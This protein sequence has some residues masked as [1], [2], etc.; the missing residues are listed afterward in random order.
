MTDV[1]RARSP[2][3]PAGRAAAR[4]LPGPDGFELRL[5][6]RNGEQLLLALVIP[7]VALIG[8]TAV[9]VIELPRT[10]GRHRDAGHL[11]L[12]I[13]STGFTSMAIST[14]L[15]P[16]VRGDQA[17]DRVGGLAAGPAGR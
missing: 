14:R 5:L 11:A 17:T 12:A 16:P 15:R 6:V 10:A 9:T 1:P 13:L 3:R 4:M 7:I 2:R 8:M